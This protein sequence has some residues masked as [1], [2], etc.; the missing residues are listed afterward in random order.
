MKTKQQLS[1][2]SFFSGSGLLDL[3]FEKHGYS[4]CF[5]NEY[6]TPFVDAYKYS[7]EQLK[8]A[9]PKY[10]HFDCPIDDFLEKDLSKLKG[11]VE[12]EKSTGALVGFIGGPPCPDFSV[13]GKNRGKEGVNGRLSQSYIDLIYK[14]EPDWVL[15][16]NVKGLWRTKKHREFYEKIKAEISKKYH[17]TERLIN[18]IEAGC[19]QDRDRILMFGVLKKNA[20]KAN[21]DWNAGLPFPNRTAFEDYSWV[22]TTPFIEHSNL[23]KPN[24]IPVELTVQHWFD[25]NDVENHPNQND[26]FKPRQGIVKFKSVLEGDVSRKSSKRVHRWR[27]SPTAAYGNNEV[28]LHPYKARRLTVAEALAIQSMPKDFILPPDMS[29]T[30]KFKT[31]G[32]G[33]PFLLGSHV[34]T[35][36]ES[37]LLQNVVK[38]SK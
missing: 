33:V 31:I 35:V 15:F 17:V 16:E 27:Y 1:V 11:F 26:C 23:A 4:V 3:A 7:R 20:K 10:G 30:N 22:D 25:V 38:E 2:F 29:L 18:S 37:F 19:P 21:L 8:I 13:G 32:N 12:K 9:A 34:A 6:F 28:H 14:T 36:I 5:V 24:N